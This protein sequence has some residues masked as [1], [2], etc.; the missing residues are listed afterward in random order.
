MN[1]W[2]YI[3]KVVVLNL[4]L[5]KKKNVSNFFTILNFKILQ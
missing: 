5:K 3:E 2:T 1:S 4:V